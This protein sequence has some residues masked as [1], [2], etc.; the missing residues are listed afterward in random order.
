M[1]PRAART[2][3]VGG[4]R[5]KRGWRW[6]IFR[7]FGCWTDV[8]N[9]T[10]LGMRQLVSKEEKTTTLYSV[11]LRSEKEAGGPIGFGA[12]IRHF[13]FPVCQFE[14]KQ[15]HCGKGLSVSDPVAPHCQN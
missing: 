11:C 1:C 6:E 12:I 5:S 7:Q 13:H 4:K 2:K 3:G 9:S 14:C 8:S 10:V 15:C